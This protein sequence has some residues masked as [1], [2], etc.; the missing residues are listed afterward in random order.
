MEIEK[1]TRHD[2]VAFTRAVSETLGEE[3]KW[4]HYGLTSTD[5]VDTAYGYL[6]KQANDILREDLKR[7]TEIIGEKAKE[8]KYTVMMGR[9]HGVHAEP[10]TF[11]LK[12]A[13]WYSE[14][15]RN[16]ERFEHAAKGVEAGK[17]SGAVGTFANIPPFIE[18][19]VC[20]QL[21]IRPQEISTQVLLGIYMLNIS[22]MALIATS[23]ERFATEIRGL[24]KSETREVEEFLRKVKRFFCYAAQKESD[25]FRK[26]GWSSQSGARTHG[27]CL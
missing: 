5:V 2:V 3:R 6:I 27:H 7:F 14:M 10:T 8:H 20:K 22:A 16:I 26:Y 21:G 19:Y 11:G 25:R 4:V 24:Q 23:I 12:L 9:T 17:I 1:L 15:K 13:T 18:E